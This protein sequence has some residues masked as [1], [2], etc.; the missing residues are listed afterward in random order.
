MPEQITVVITSCGRLDLLERT[1][2]SFLSYNSYPIVSYVIVEDSGDLHV[3]SLLR[4][5]YGGSF[6]IL[7]NEQHLG[8][9][10]SIDRAYATV[11]TPYIFHCE[12]DWLFHRSRFLEESLS[13]L[14]T[15]PQI[16]TVSLRD[17]WDTNGHPPERPRYLTPDGVCFRHMS[18]HYLSPRGFIW[19]GFSF[20]PGL[21]RTADYQRLGSYAVV[22]K[23]RG[24]ASCF[25]GLPQESAIGECYHQLGY[26]AA[27]LEQGAVE[28][29]GYGRHVST[30]T[31]PRTPSFLFRPLSE[32]VVTATATASQLQEMSAKI[33]ESKKPLT[34]APPRTPLF[35][36]TTD[37][38]GHLV[39]ALLGFT[40][41]NVLHISVMWVADCPTQ[42]KTLAELFSKTEAEAIRRGCNEAFATAVR[43]ECIGMLNQF[44]YTSVSELSNMRGEPPRAF[45]RKR[46][47]DD[48]ERAS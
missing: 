25:E 3:A 48:S 32:T 26:Y 34:C 23:E 4:E 17:L 19:R 45:L 22:L 11:A 20:N 10:A 2:S 35:A 7:F 27:I 40:H 36:F 38:R 43:P 28:H 12:D 42:D 18:R 15:D 16:A 29:I 24:M 8:Q 46:L 41:V 14:G 37:E 9:I 21:R 47:P 44:G 5:R 33:A 1:I 30:Q 39:G 13:V 31:P 6:N